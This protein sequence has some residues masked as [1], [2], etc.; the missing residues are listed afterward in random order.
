MPEK[1][2][3]V[4]STVEPAVLIAYVVSVDSGNVSGGS[5]VSVPVG[6]PLDVSVYL[7]YVDEGYVVVSPFGT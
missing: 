3:T 5:V 6:T 2:G 4:I 7:V 1:Y